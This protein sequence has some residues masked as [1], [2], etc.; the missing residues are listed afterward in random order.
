MP[1]DKGNAP[2]SE[3]IG[4]VARLLWRALL[5]E[6]GRMRPLAIIIGLVIGAVVIRGEPALAAQPTAVLRGHTMAQSAVTYSAD[7]RYLATASYDRTAKV[8]DAA[9]GN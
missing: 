2:M 1:V 6:S 7:G 4:N 9:T 3:K 8:W 5:G